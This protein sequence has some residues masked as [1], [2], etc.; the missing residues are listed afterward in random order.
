MPRGGQENL[1][2][3]D[4]RTKEEQRE[5]QVKGGIASGKA[6]R[7][8]ADMRKLMNMM[9]A[10]NIP[11]QNMTYAH[12]LTKSILTIAANPKNTG[13]AVRAYETVLRITGQD[14]PEQRQDTIELLASILEVNRKNAERLQSEQE[15]TDIHN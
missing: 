12:R 7:E 2:P 10:E 9:L 13:A 4:K 6:R 15:T 8:K 14:I 1:K 5:I 3:L 11:G